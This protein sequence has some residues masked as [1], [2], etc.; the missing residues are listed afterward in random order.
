MVIL[1]LQRTHNLLPQ[2]AQAR[3]QRSCAVIF[4]SILQ[5]A[6]VLLLEY[7]DTHTQTEM[8]EKNGK[9]D[10]NECTEFEL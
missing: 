3:I 5:L 4:N 1:H 10:L 7:K 6:I 8:Q 2:L 9:N